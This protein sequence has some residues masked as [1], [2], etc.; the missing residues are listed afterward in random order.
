MR[1]ALALILWALVGCTTSIP[2]STPIP[3]GQRVT[4]P[5]GWI[6]Y[7]AEH[8]EDTGCPNPP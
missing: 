3:G 5:P 7:C 2:R 4:P 1:V 6:V 8:P